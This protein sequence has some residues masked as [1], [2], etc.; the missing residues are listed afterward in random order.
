MR[1]KLTALAV[2][3]AL[4]FGHFIPAAAQAPTWSAEQQ[5]VWDV[6]SRSWSD[7]VARNGRWPGQY[8]HAN[9]VSWSPEWPM[10]RYRDSIER[11]SR[12]SDSQS[13]VMQYEIS[14]TAI[15][16]AG[17]TAVVHY[18]SVAMRQRE[19]PRGE[20]RPEAKREAYGIVETLVR[21]G[22]GWR[23]LS[24]SSFPL[25]GGGAN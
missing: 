14:P 19:V 23:F 25:G 7:E 9:V 8:V 1:R 2:A 6:V 18:T 13:R 20:D 4:T 24:S 16:L 10:P 22:P 11:W 3:G 5:A 15:T 12:W 17:N 21:E